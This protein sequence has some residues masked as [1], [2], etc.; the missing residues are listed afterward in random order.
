MA[1]S[2]LVALLI[3]VAPLTSAHGVVT[4]APPFTG[5]T[6]LPYNYTAH[7]GCA[8]EKQP[9]APTWNAPAGSFQVSSSVTSG[10]CTYGF[11]EA[12]NTLTLA[13]P[14]FSSPYVGFGYLDVSVAAA[15]SA[16]A[17]AHLATVN[18]TNGSYAY[19]ES[20][21][22]L[23]V[24]VYIYDATHHN[25][26]LFGYAIDSVVSQ[27]FSG[28]GTFTMTSS[29]ANT[30]VYVFGTFT[31]GH[32]YQAQVYVTAQVFAYTAGGGSTAGASLDLAGTNGLTLGAITAS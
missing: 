16:R 20:S 10:K 21:V 14:L 19:A 28:T 12:Y 30:V 32:V 6:T 7:S 3:L 31:G 1:L 24:S 13:S 17:A 15:F 18:V 22:Y 2:G 23:S 9:T 8:A 11:A 4:F 27:S 25:D 5:F 29:S 26:T